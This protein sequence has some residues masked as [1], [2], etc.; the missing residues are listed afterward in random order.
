MYEAIEADIFS[1]FRVQTPLNIS[2]ATQ[3]GN[4]ALS[5]LG[6]VPKNINRLRGPLQFSCSRT[7]NSLIKLM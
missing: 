4:T 6:V 3:K 2:M 7:R 1:V 5:A